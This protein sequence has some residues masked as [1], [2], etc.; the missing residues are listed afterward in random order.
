MGLIFLGDG[1]DK[2]ILGSISILCIL[3]KD[4]VVDEKIWIES[5][6]IAVV[7]NAEP[8]VQ[9]VS[10]FRP[11]LIFLP[12]GFGLKFNIKP[13]RHRIDIS[14]KRLLNIYKVL[15]LPEYTLNSC[16]CL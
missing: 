6:A 7:L 3:F 8:V 12:T 14:K 13:E 10:V 9:F 2:L 11:G 1:F 16:Y 4:A 15:N 5:G